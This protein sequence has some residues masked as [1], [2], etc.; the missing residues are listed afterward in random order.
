MDGMYTYLLNSFL[1]TFKRS[2]V[3]INK[4][5]IFQIINRVSDNLLSIFLKNNAF[6]FN[7]YSTQKHVC[8][9][10]RFSPILKMSICKTGFSPVVTKI[11]QTG[12]F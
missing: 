7:V 9:E 10:K 4:H 1:F 3:F 11:T 6:V 12:D 2:F 8:K 5:F